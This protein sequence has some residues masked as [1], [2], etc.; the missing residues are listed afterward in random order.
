MDKKR[1]NNEQFK[2]VVFNSGDGVDV[3]VEPK[4]SLDLIGCD[5]FEYEFGEPRRKVGLHC[6]F[7][8]HGV[9]KT[10][11]AAK[12]EENLYDY[13]NLYDYADDG[14]K[15]NFLID[16]FMDVLH[17]GADDVIGGWCDGCG[18]GFANTD[19]KGK[20]LHDCD[21]DEAVLLLDEP[22]VQMF[23]EDAYCV[24]PDELLP[25]KKDNEIYLWTLEKVDV[26][27]GRL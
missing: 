14:D 27:T 7:H 4:Y 23:W 15:D 9:I 5:A 26:F 2:L 3:I 21:W 6:R 8:F 17:D 16:D 25:E 13:D 20:Y 19:A 11:D 10:K 18:I 1:I 24:W 12:N 22:M